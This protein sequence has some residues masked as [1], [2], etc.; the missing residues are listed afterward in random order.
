[1]STTTITIK[2]S[3]PENLPFIPIT[4]QVASPITPFELPSSLTSLLSG[5]FDDYLIEQEPSAPDTTPVWSVTAKL[6]Y[7]ERFR[8]KQ[9]D[10]GALGNRLEAV[11]NELKEI[12]EE[13]LK[14]KKEAMEA[15]KAV[16]EVKKKAAEIKIEVREM[17]RSA[18][19]RESCLATVEGYTRLSQGMI[20][21]SL[22][23]QHIWPY[24]SLQFYTIIG[25][26]RCQKTSRDCSRL[27][28]RAIVCF[29]FKF[30][31]G[32]IQFY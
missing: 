3:I 17:R 27:V 5:S 19:E 30:R 8:E 7:Q 26:T 13:A 11:E 4:L 24:C 20:I 16:M 18:E 31:R 25:L 29:F 9:L 12:K 21:F 15:E 6:S 22:F 14:A 1:M 2:R 28:H 10:L 32:V 23:S